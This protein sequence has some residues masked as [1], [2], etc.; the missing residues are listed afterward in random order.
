[1]SPHCMT[2]WYEKRS[3]LLKAAAGPREPSNIPIIVRHAYSPP[4]VCT[5]PWDI[6]TIPRSVIETPG[7]NEISIFLI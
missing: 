2:D 3:Y 6:V 7:E 1:M 5:N 4:G